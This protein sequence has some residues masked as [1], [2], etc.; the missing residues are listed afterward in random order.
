MLQPAC[1]PGGGCSCKEREA[2][3]SCRQ[4][5]LWKWPADQWGSQG[6]FR[7][8]A[9]NWLVSFLTFFRGPGRKRPLSMSDYNWVRL[10]FPACLRLFSR[11]SGM[12]ERAR[13]FFC[14]S[15]WR[16]EELPSVQHPNLLRRS[17]ACRSPVPEDCFRSPRSR[18]CS[19]RQEQSELRILWPPPLIFSCVFICRSLSCQRITLHKNLF[20]SF[21]C[22]SIVTI[23]CLTGVANNQQLVAANPVGCK[24]AQF[25]HLYLMVCNYFWMLCEGIY[26]H[27]LIVVAV[28]A[29]KQHLLWYYL[30]GWEAML[31]TPLGFSSSLASCGGGYMPFDTQLQHCPS[32]QCIQELEEKRSYWSQCNGGGFGPHVKKEQNR[33]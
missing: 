3:V 21:V 11:D 14:C 6:L 33:S 1:R 23:I 7:A 24:V 12:S 8:E 10:P 29:E 27:T 30:L 18:L 20:F 31:D 22:N 2:E 13:L 15:E 17:A 28:F 32:P 9:E 19:L 26:L 4:D 16:R 5:P 25:F